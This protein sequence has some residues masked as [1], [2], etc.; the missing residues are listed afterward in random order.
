MRMNKQLVFYVAVVDMPSLMASFKALGCSQNPP[1][2][3]DTA[4]WSQPVELV[5]SSKSQG[6]ER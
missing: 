5:A 2:A 4:A 1:F 3:G 6:E